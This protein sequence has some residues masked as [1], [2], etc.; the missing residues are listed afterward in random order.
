[1]SPCLHPELDLWLLHCL[2]CLVWLMVLP[3][4]S[5]SHRSVSLLPYAL[6]HDY[7]AWAQKAEV[8]VQTSRPSRTRLQST[9]LVTRWAEP[10]M[11][12][13]Q[14]WSEKQDFWRFKILSH[15][16][17]QTRVN[18]CVEVWDSKRYHK[19]S[20]VI[21]NLHPPTHRNNCVLGCIKVQLEL[22]EAIA[23]HKIFV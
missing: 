2:S 5:H 8:D 20:V 3:Y 18:C 21:M 4:W 19:I 13:Y 15:L 1:M 17:C 16:T 11:L 6:N 7:V 23:W 22:R 12:A 10:W 14:T 9:D